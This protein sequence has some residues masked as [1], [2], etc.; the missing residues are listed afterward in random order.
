MLVAIVTTDVVSCKNGRHRIERRPLK[1]LLV[2]LFIDFFSCKIVPIRSELII[3]CDIIMLFLGIVITRAILCLTMVPEPPWL[4]MLT[5]YIIRCVQFST[6][7]RRYPCFI[8]NQCNNWWRGPRRWANAMNARVLFLSSTSVIVFHQ[9]TGAITN[10]SGG[11]IRLFLTGTNTT[12]VVF[13]SW[14]RTV[15]D[16]TSIR[17]SLLNFSLTLLLLLDIAVSIA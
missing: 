17:N 10:H 4:A 7:C 8:Y 6:S 9:N 15:A 11:E 13:T 14:S 5:D 12:P 1:R 3:C 2:I 16:N